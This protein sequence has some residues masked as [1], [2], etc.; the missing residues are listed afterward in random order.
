[1]NF[2]EEVIENLESHQLELQTMIGMGKFVDFFR[3]RVLHWQGTLGQMEDVLKVWV[4]VSRSWAALESI[5][6]ASADIRSQLPDDT[7]RFEGIDSEFKELMKDAVVGQPHPYYLYVFPS[8][9]LVL[10]IECAHLY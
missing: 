1:M 6:L 3:D 2:S 5:F 7:K 4:N 10:C 8:L 9:K